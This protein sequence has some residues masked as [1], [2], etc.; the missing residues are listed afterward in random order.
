MAKKENNTQETDT[1]VRGITRRTALKTAGALV[2][3]GIA[4]VPAV[5]TRPV[6]RVQA[7]QDRFY[8]A[9]HRY[10]GGVWSLV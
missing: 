4:G 5:F 10:W 9:S 8:G 6:G 1:K 3:A 2:G 7:Y